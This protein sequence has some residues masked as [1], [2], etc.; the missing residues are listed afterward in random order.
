MRDKERYEYR[1]HN[2]LCATCGKNLPDEYT[3]ITCDECRE[4]NRLLYSMRKKNNVCAKC[5]KEDAYTMNGR[6]VCG[7]RRKTERGDA[8]L[9]R[10]LV[11]LAE[12]QREM[13][14]NI[15]AAERRWKLHFLWKKTSA[16]R[17]ARP[18]RYLPHIP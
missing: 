3:Y 8:A 2:H 7:M 1:K 18:L 12:E 17:K 6:A 10:D 4:Y 16:L 13:E 9:Q 5:G 15:Q 11:R 14:A